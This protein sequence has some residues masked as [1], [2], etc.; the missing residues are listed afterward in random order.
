MEKKSCV[1]IVLLV[2]LL[3]AGGIY[4]AKIPSDALFPKLKEFGESLAKG[5]TAECRKFFISYLEIFGMY[6]EDIQGEFALEQGHILL[7]RNLHGTFY[8]GTISGDVKVTL[9]ENVSYRVD[10]KFASVDFRWFAMNMFDP[11][12]SLKGNL[13]GSV[14]LAGNLEGEVHGTLNIRL[15]DGY[16]KSL[17][18]WFAMFTLVNLNPMRG[19]VISSANVKLTIEKDKFVIQKCELDT[20]DVTVFV[21]PGGTIDFNGNADFV[22]NPVGKH[23]IASIFLFGVVWRWLDQLILRIPVKGPLLTPSFRLS[24]FDKL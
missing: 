5:L 4:P 22:L 14:N 13:R 6:A 2:L 10:L 17:P 20:E 23:R 8:G 12:T 16:L 1:I 15:K 24:A 7:F 11:G 9:G 3:T 18:R 19:N 21:K